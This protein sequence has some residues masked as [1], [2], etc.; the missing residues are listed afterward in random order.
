MNTKK[1][2]FAKRA[3]YK[4]KNVQVS[5]PDS[6]MTN[7]YR[8]RIRDNSYL[9]KKGYT[10]P[11]EN[12]VKE[13]L[14]FLYKDL[15]CKPMTFGPAAAAGEDAAFPVYRENENKMYIPRFYGIERYGTP[16]RSEIAPGMDIDVAFPKE[17]RD[18]QNNIIDIFTRAVTPAPAGGILE[19]YCGAGKCLG[20]NTPIL[21]RDGSVKMVQDVHVGDILMGD[22]STP[23]NVMTLA[24]GREKMYRVDASDDES[25]TV[26]ESHI[27]SL[28]VCR[29]YSK[30]YEE[31]SVHDISVKDYLML[32]KTIQGIL[33]GYR[34]QLDYP[35]LPVPVDP[36]V[37]GHIAAIDYNLYRVPRQ[38]NYIIPR[39]I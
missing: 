39:C 23:R 5:T 3:F 32:P 28:K 6:Y 7:E 11:K 2:F 13:D 19:I 25:Y 4:P 12:L 17:L 15:F 29:T 22:D 14:D 8:Q 9:G 21:M 1:A 27:L 16:E 10:I 37:M 30:A 36:Y 31:G 35:D 18:Y 26:N 34:T 20:L 24:R 33:L 38:C